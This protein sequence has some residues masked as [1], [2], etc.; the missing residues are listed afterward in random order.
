[1][2][3]VSKSRLMQAAAVLTGAIVLT[4]AAPAFAQDYPP[5]PSFSAGQ[6][7]S[8]VSRIA[9][10]PDPLLAQIFAAAS[11]PDQ[12]PEAAQW[13]NQNRNLRGEQLADAIYQANLQFDPAVQALIPFPDV[14]DMMARDMSWTQALGNAVLADRPGLM[15]AVQRLRHS[16]EQYGYLQSN[17]QMR[18]VDSGS[19]VDIEPVDPGVIAVP[20]YDPYVVYAPPRPGFYAGSAIGFGPSCYIGA[21]GG[22]GW[23]GGF[24]WS[25]H[26]VIVNRSVWGRTWYN[27]D[28]YVHN[29]GNWDRGNWRNTYMNRGAGFYGGNS[30][31]DRSYRNTYQAPVQQYRG[32][33]DRG[34]SGNYRTSQQPAY[35][36]PVQQNRG[37]FD[38]SYSGNHLSSQQPVYQAPVQQSR[39]SFDRSNGGSSAPVQ[40]YPRP[41][42]SFGGESHAAQPQPQQSRGFAGSHGSEGGHY[43]RGG[44]GRR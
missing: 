5:P 34:Y 28:A 27:R 4:T 33:F 43:D 15:D 23:G 16:S 30:G 8:L 42:N 25:N 37:G 2:K 44:F 14:L 31:Y 39:G 26:A 40:N 36:A 17:Q 12:I 7:D 32:G 41:S 13:S 29:Y 24:N 21:F 18:V 19:G 22:W 1:M 11:F 20:V 38:R 10:Y 9:L 3:L 6:V 35:Q